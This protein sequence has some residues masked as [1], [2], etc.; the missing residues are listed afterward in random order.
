MSRDEVREREC[1]HVT[2][3]VRENERALLGTIHNG[4]L[5]LRASTWSRDQ[6]REPGHVTLP[7]HV[8]GVPPAKTLELTKF[9]INP[10][11]CVARNCQT[12]LVSKG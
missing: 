5:G 4:G 12:V 1:G 2:R 10:G 11:L 7:M 6:V 9:R 3:C 8:A